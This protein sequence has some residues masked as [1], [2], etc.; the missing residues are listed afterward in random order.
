MNGRARRR[1]WRSWVA[2]ALL[3]PTVACVGDPVGPRLPAGAGE[4]RVWAVRAFH[5]GW[6]AHAVGTGCAAF[7]NDDGT[8]SWAESYV[9]EALIDLYL[10]GH[11]GWY[12]ERFVEHADAVL[13]RRDSRRGVMDYRGVSADVWSAT[14]YST[15]GERA[16]WIVD[17]AVIAAPLARFALV[18][19]AQWSDVPPRLLERARLYT[20]AARLAMAAFDADYR[21]DSEGRG[22]YILPAGS[23]TVTGHPS[24]DRPNPLNWDV[25]AGLVHLY[26]ARLDAPGPHAARAIAIAQRLRSELVLDV[27]RFIWHYWA[28]DGRALFH[29]G[30]EDISHGAI[31]ATF[32]EQMASAALVF[33]DTDVLRV[34]ATLLHQGAPA[35]GF[36]RRVNGPEADVILDDPKCGRVWRRAYSD[37]SGLWLGLGRVTPALVPAVGDYLRARST[38]EVFDDP[39]FLAGLARFALLSP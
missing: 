7:P 19:R 3:A 27:D 22:R 39:Q 11:D 24:E 28:A 23:P 13:A 2:L 36:L 1:S 12:L 35:G 32:I 17:Q 33:D 9:L 31:E 6:R 8:L 26:L 20:E 4:D 14:R 34:A 10:V 21:E 30:W 5:E 25:S 38:S 15:A 29:A 16:A 18:V 37:A